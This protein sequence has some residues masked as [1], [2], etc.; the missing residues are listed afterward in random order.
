MAETPPTGPA[1]PGPGKLVPKRAT[2]PDWTAIR[3]QFVHQNAT[4]ADL[5]K[6]HD[7]KQ[8]T[9][10]KRAQREGW[11]DERAQV[12]QTAYAESAAKAAKERVKEL[13]AFNSADLNVARGLR[14]RV[15]KRLNETDANGN[16]K[17]IK[18]AEL[19]QL[20]MVAET[21][22]RMGRLALGASTDN[23]GVGGTGGEGPVPV[24]N[25]S[26]EEYL[27]ARKAILEEF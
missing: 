2:G 11:H 7:I 27:E 1:E 8:D 17:V 25:V 24:A 15:E 16:P 3:F 18:P 12:D 23:L 5:A 6:L 26:R 21:A 22:Q 14:A 4:L 10:K 13:T 20:A 9:I 19:R